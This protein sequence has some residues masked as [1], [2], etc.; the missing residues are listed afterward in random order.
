MS[1]S[2]FTSPGSPGLDTGDIDASDLAK[3]TGPLRRGW[4]TGAC[5]TAATKAA[6]TAL[7]TGQFPDPVDITLPGGKTAMFSLARHESANQTATAAVIKDAGDDPDVTHGALVIATVRTG[8]PGSGVTFK[9]G[10]GVGTVTKPGLPIPPGEPAIN[11]VPRSMMQTAI[12]EV[13]QMTDATGDVEIEIAI[14]GGEALAAKT[15]NPRLGI[16]GGLSVLGTTG[17]V[18]PYSC[19]AWIHSIHRSVDVARATHISHI[20]GTTGSTSERA[21][22]SLYG[23]PESALVEMGDFVGGFLKYARKHPVPHITIGGGFAKMTKLGQGFLDLH[24]RRGNVDFNWLSEQLTKAGAPDD[25][26]A[27]TAEANTAQQVLQDSARRNIP[28][29]DV[30]AQAAFDTA[31]HVVVGTDIAIDI[32]VFDR[33]GKIVGRAGSP[34]ET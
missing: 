17:I 9:A 20:A 25:L 3:P 24:S 16:I 28:L 12:A 30:V 1:H 14:P 29:G 6:Y 26:I 32:V 19:A 22:Q 15:M 8:K 21:V 23:L 4:T 34:V 27:S 5:A 13:A 7:E 10:D 2:K 18:V 33:D 31:R 11:P